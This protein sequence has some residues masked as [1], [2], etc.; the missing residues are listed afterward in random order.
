MGENKK[1]RRVIEALQE[2]IAQH[3]RKIAEEL[4]KPEPN[5]GVIAHWET[6]IRA[7]MKTISRR[8]KR[9]PGGRR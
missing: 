6:E 5:S 9:L 2:H 1:N 3:E 7:A 4:A 8:S